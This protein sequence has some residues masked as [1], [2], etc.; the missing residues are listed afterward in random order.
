MYFGFGGS[1]PYFPGYYYVPVENLQNPSVVPGQSGIPIQPANTAFSWNY[2]PEILS[3]YLP[4]SSI[5]QDN[6][7]RNNENGENEVGQ[8]VQA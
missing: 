3:S 5:H 8:T 4:S 2:N 6:S 7:N 1:N